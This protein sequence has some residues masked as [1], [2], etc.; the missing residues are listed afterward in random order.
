[1]R[2]S[3]LLATT[4]GA[5][6]LLARATLGAVAGLV[7]ASGVDG[8]SRDSGEHCYELYEGCR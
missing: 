7:A 3:K 2:V 1:M 6:A 4:A 8:D 5:L